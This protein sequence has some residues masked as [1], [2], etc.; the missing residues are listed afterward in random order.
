MKMKKTQQTE[1]EE[2]KRSRAITIE[3]EKGYFRFLFSTRA[4]FLLPFGAIFIDILYVKE[5]VPSEYM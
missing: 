5:I 3:T 1:K 2:E 4:V